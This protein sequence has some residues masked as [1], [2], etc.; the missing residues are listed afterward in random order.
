[1]VLTAFEF[2]AFAFEVFEF[3]ELVLPPQADRAA[4]ESAQ[5]AVNKILRTL[6]S[7]KPFRIDL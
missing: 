5:E 2:A 1:V 7:S 3:V 4:R 6:L